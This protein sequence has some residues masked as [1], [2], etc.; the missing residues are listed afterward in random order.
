MLQV[1]LPLTAV[2][3][4]GMTE[5]QKE[6]LLIEWSLYEPRAQQAIIDEYNYRIGK[7]DFGYNNFLDFLRDK[8]EIE[9]YWEKIGLV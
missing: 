7:G 3:E 8:L 5:E 6:D 1:I 4:D 2:G 9:G